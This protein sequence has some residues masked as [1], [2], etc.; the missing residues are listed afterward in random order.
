MTKPDPTIAE[1]ATHSVW[2]SEPC[3]CAAT[4]DHDRGQEVRP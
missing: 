1:A 3:D 2:W 4:D